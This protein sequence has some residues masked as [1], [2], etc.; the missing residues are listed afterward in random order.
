M[1]EHNYGTHLIKFKADRTPDGNYWIGKAHVQYNHGKTLRCFE[2]HGPAEK[3][4]SK[5]A[6]EQHVLGVAKTLIDNFIWLNLSEELTMP[7]V[8]SYLVSAARAR[9]TLTSGFWSRCYGLA[10]AE[11]PEI[12]G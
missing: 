12:D 5:E 3:F 1:N 4:D 11:S 7:A 9:L 8:F 6:A 10:A 2:V